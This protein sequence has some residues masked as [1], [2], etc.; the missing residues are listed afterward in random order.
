MHTASYEFVMKP[1][2]SAGCHQTL[3]SRVG[4]GDET[5]HFPARWKVVWARDYEGGRST[6]TF[7]PPNKFY[8]PPSYIYIGS[9]LGVI[10]SGKSLTRAPLTPDFASQLSRK[11]KPGKTQKVAK[12]NPGCEATHADACTHCVLPG[13][14]STVQS[15]E[16]KFPSVGTGARNSTKFQRRENL[17]SSFDMALVS[18]GQSQIHD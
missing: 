3:S 16:S 2:E 14:S 13:L 10:L 12:Q 9:E 6:P 7:W 15:P 1:K 5:N 8:T 18:R 4:S 11:S 17:I